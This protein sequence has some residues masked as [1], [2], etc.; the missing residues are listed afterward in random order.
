[1]VFVERS[2]KLIE[3]MGITKNKLLIDLGLGKNSFVDWAGGKTP[4]AETV[5]K[6]A[7]YFNVS[8]DYLL[9]KSDNPPTPS[10]SGGPTKQIEKGYVEIYITSADGNNEVRK[11]PADAIP[12][13]LSAIDTYIEQQNKKNKK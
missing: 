11:V 6:I 9:G 5:L 12:F 8:T 10:L 3:K 1:M 13:A 7:D 2:L 4:S